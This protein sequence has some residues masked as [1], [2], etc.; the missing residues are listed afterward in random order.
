MLEADSFSLQN[1]T[2]RQNPEQSVRQAMLPQVRRDMGA[3]NAASFMPAGHEGVRASPPGLASSVRA[4]QSTRHANLGMDGPSESGYNAEVDGIFEPYGSGCNAEMDGLSEPYPARQQSRPTYN[5]DMDG[6]SEPNPARHQ[7]R[8]GYTAEMDRLQDGFSDPSPA[9]QQSRLGYTAEMG[10]LQDCFSEPGPA[11]QQSRPVNFLPG[12]IDPVPLCRDSLAAH[13]NRF[14][15]GY[16]S[17][18]QSLRRSFDGRSQS[19]HHSFHTCNDGT[20][21]C[22]SENQSQRHGKRSAVNTGGSTATTCTEDYDL[23]SVW[24]SLNTDSSSSTTL[25][26][27]D[28]MEEE[29]CPITPLDLEVMNRFMSK[30]G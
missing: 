5:A 20:S 14:E 21:E 1:L 8:M 12:H 23:H 28:S 6:L 11:R 15:D 25:S 30:F 16:A 10:R 29:P 13:H 4:S 17:W 22:Y 2:N 3:S 26:S 24:S 7:S 27:G 18:A 9:R 19:S